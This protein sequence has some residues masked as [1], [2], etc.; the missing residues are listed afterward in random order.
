MVTISS[1]AKMKHGPDDRSKQQYGLSTE[2]IMSTLGN[3]LQLEKHDIGN[4]M[5]CLAG[6]W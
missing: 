5:E 1:M 3:A 2:E 6:M 4:A